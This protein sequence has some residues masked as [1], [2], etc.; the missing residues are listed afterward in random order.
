MSIMPQL[1]QLSQSLEGTLLYD[2]LH[3]ILYSTDASAYRI[4]PIAVAIPQTEEDIVKII[5]DNK[6]QIEYEKKEIDKN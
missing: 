4:Q 5:Y 1:Q 3:K 2:E 6:I